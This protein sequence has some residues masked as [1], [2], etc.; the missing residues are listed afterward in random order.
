[1]TIFFSSI[2][3]QYLGKKVSKQ[4]SLFPTHAINGTHEFHYSD[5]NSSIIQIYTY[6]DISIP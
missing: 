1:M 3:R 4:E 2:L 6:C 5:I